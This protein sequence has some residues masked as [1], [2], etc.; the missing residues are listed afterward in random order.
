MMNKEQSLQ[1]KGV[2]I[3][4][5]LFLHLFNTV[6]RVAECTTYVNFLNGKPLVYALARVCGMCV[7]I[8][9]FISGYGLAYSARFDMRSFLRRLWRVFCR[10][11]LV[12]ALFIPVGC[13][14]VPNYYPGSIQ[15]LVLN[16]LALSDTYNGEWWFLLPY[17]LLLAMARWIVPH[18]QRISPRQSWAEFFVLYGLSVLGQHVKHVGGDLY[19]VQRLVQFFFVLPAFYA[20]VCCGS[21]ATKILE[22]VRSIRHPL[23]WMGGLLFIRCFLGA[24]ILNVL[25]CVPFVLLFIQLRLNR[26]VQSVLSFLGR[27]STIMWLTHTFYA[28]YFFHTQL[29]ALRNPLL[30]YVT[31][32]TI[33]LLTAIPLEWLA[34]HFT[35]PQN[36]R[37]KT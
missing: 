9:L 5:M 33:T 4:M 7:P 36:N 37:R 32:L 3:L 25:F 12:F 24:S 1:L 28:Y 30:I 23:L 15:E 35:E 13:F 16:F 21:R 8:Y 20:G 6:D 17:V 26:S 18:V 14:L 2:A 29:Y 31:L 19:V 11:W 10:Y 34:N 22:Y 27:H